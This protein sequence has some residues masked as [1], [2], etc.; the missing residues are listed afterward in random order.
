[1]MDPISQTPVF[2]AKIDLSSTGGDILAAVAGIS[3][4]VLEWVFTNTTAGTVT[5]RSNTTALTGAMPFGANG[6]AAPGFNPCGSLQT[7][8]G[9]SL[10]L[11]LSSTG[12]VSGYV[13][14]QK[15]GGGSFPS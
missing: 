9:E 14:Y 11:L 4:R 12:Q 15:L 1:M 13:V 10:N 2:R 7:A 5:W 6:G 8:V 3:Y